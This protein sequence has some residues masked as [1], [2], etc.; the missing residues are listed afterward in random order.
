VTAHVIIGNGPAGVV[1][2]ETL[3]QVDPQATITLLG[4]EA[5]PP[6]SR[7]AI[8]YLLMGEIGEA[9]CY[10]RKE[11]DHFPARQI[12]LRHGRVQAVATGSRQV[13]LADG[14]ALPYDRLLIAS[15]ARAQRPRL[16]GIDLPQVLSCWTLADARALAV[17]V[18]PGARVLQMGAGF[19]GCI[20]LE[21]LKVR[22]PQL[23]VVE[24]GDRMVPRMMDEVAGAMIGRWCEQRGVGVRTGRC[25]EEISTAGEELRVTLDNGEALAV[26]VVISATGVRPNVDFLAGSGVEVAAGIVVDETMQTSVAGVYAAGDVAEAVEFGTG[27]RVLNAIQPNAVEQARV[28]ALNMAGRGGRLRATFPFNVLDT[29]GLIS[30]SFGQWQGVSGGETAQLLDEAA[31][32]YLRLA[33]DGDR[34]VGANSI[35]HTEHIGVLRGLIQGQVRLGSWKDRLLANPLLLSEAYLAR[36][37]STTH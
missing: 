6:Y 18:V 26:D 9:G 17:R 12:E 21:S 22:G 32:R 28:A 1:A 29:L 33:F 15:G 5:E 27:R 35:G 16:P 20:I 19:I 10:L 24:M 23:T 36:G 7:M 8:P 14:S 30:A 31:Y 25:V 34:L 3:R 13:L 37:L 4:D 11:A 2:A